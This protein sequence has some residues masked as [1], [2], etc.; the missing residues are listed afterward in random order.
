MQYLL[1]NKQCFL[2]G[3]TDVKILLDKSAVFIWLQGL[4]RQ[5]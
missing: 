4:I 5:I 2:K 3:E 1:H